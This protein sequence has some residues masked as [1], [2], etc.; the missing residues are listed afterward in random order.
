MDFI[1]TPI[2]FL[3]TL[4]S[5]EC[6][7][8]S[9]YIFYIINTHILYIYIYILQ[10]FDV[11]TIL[12]RLYSSTNIYILNI[13]E[14][15]QVKNGQYTHYDLTCSSAP[16]PHVLKAILNH[17]GPHWKRNLGKVIV[18]PAFDKTS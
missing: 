14:D 8:N 17:T 2:F 9:L 16:N 3:K 6:L 10:Q 13:T 4:F 1:M 7:I 15:K 18:G 12:D 11:Q 5:K